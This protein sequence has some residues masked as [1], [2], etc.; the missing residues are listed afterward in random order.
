MDAKE[1]LVYK[2]IVLTFY[3]VFIFLNAV[4]VLE[5]DFLETLLVA[6]EREFSTAPHH[7]MGNL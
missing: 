7:V 1:E 2:Q 3:L 5:T 6:T 4:G